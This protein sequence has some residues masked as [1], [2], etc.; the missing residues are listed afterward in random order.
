MAVEAR[1]GVLQRLADVAMGRAGGYKI[2]FQRFV[3]GAL[4]D[5]QDEVGRAAADLDVLRLHDGGHRVA[6]LA[7]ARRAIEQ[8]P[9]QKLTSQASRLAAISSKNNLCS[10]G[11]TCRR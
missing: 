7:Q 9:Q 10:S 2:T 4:L 8:E 11:Q 3:L 6:A 1:Y 5:E